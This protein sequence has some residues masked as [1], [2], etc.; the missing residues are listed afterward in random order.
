MQNKSPRE[1]DHPEEVL[2]LVDEQD[3]VIGSVTRKEVYAQGL[4]NY[5]VIHAF[6]INSEGKIWI[7]RRVETKKLYP[8]GLDYSIAG[9]VESGET[10]EEALVKE[11]QEEANLDLEKISYREIAQFNPHTHDVHC[12]QR[13]YEIKSDEAPNYNRD[14]FSGYEWLTPQEVIERFKNGELM[15]ED[16]PE[17]LKLCYLNQ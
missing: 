5:R 17:V 7:P 6:I 2:D 9:H 4:R 3:N 1:A 8:G 15:K 12:F 13:V 16:I 11:A 10:Y 14:D